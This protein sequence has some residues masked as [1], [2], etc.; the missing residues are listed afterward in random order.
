MGKHCFWLDGECSTDHG[1]LCS[2]NNTYN[3]PERDAESVEIP[4]RNGTLTL[5]NGRWRNIEVVYPAIIV[6]NFQKAAQDARAWLCSKPGYRR[7][8]DDYN[9]DTYRMARFVSGMSFTT[10]I[11][12][13]AGQV[14][15]TFDCMPQRFLKTGE[16]W[17]VPATGAAIHNPTLFTALPL[18]WVKALTGVTVDSTTITVGGTSFTLSDMTGQRR[19]I[20][21]ETQRAYWGTTSKDS[22]MTG[23]FPTLQPGDNTVTYDSTAVEV[24]IQPRWWTL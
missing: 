23:D 8:E 14:D 16:E 20:D 22:T 13:D 18:I 10:H 6:R 7:L 17:L 2:G 9:P 21:C 11:K 24:Q 1:I 4:G 5:D 15:L 3:A 19:Y 12:N